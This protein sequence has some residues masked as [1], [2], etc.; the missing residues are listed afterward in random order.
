MPPRRALRHQ[1]SA[2]PPPVPQNFN[3]FF[4]AMRLTFLGMQVLTISLNLSSSKNI[5][6]T[7]FRTL[8]AFSLNSMMEPK[9]TS[10]QC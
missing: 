3:Q 2:E 6:L 7:I 8:C 4:E 10:C 5:K 1:P 9:S